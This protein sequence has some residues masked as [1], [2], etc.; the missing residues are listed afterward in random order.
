MP[1][2]YFK[3]V[4]SRSTARS[5]VPQ[6]VR[7]ADGEWPL[8]WGEEGEEQQL[9]LL[10]YDRWDPNKKADRQK[11]LDWDGKT[12]DAPC[13]EFG[14]VL[15]LVAQHGSE[16]LRSGQVNDAEVLANFKPTKGT[17]RAE[18]H[19]RYQRDCLVLF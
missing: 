19:R 4:R 3:L 5:T 17:V 18:H 12:A 7:L 13:E 15:L 1:K 6:A 2:T 14:L 8:S 10:S 9:D 16:A 11:C